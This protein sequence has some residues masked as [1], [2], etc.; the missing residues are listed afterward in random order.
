MPTQDLQFEPMCHRYTVGGRFVPSVTQ[1]LS[2]VGLIDLDGIPDD[3]LR[4]AGERG[5]RVH[6]AAALLLRGQLDWASVD[7]EIGGYVLALD[8]VIRHTGF[9]PLAESVEKPLYCREF[10]FCGTPDVLAW[11]SFPRR[12]KV[13]VVFDWKTGMMSA[14]RYQLAAYAHALGVR[15]RAAVKLNHDGT[16]RMEWFLAETLRQDLETFVRALEETRRAA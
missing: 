8:K 2:A 5:T 6:Q 10:D 1:V 15:H 9:E 3:I 13:L 16:Y 4:R 7:P 14:V 12:K 11:Y